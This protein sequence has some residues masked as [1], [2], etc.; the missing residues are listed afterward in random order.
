MKRFASSPGVM[1]SF[2]NSLVSFQVKSSLDCSLL[3]QVSGNHFIGYTGWESLNRQYSVTNVTIIV[4]VE[5]DRFSYKHK[6]LKKTYN[7]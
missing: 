5:F 6:R 1:T 7:R 2:Q 4:R 3:F